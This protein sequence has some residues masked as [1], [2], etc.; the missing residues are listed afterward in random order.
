LPEGKAMAVVSVSPWQ[1]Y[2]VM[3]ESDPNKEPNVAGV[4]YP[5]VPR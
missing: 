3:R 4:G 1:R 5:P 2:K